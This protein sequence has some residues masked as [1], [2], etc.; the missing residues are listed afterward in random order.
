MAA[1]IE[2]GETLIVGKW[3]LFRDRILGDRIL[4]DPCE[5]RIGD[6]VNDVLQY[7]A[8][9]PEQGGWRRLY[10]DPGDGRLWECSRPR[11][12]MQGGGP[13]ALRVITPERAREVYGWPEPAGDG[14]Q[15][16]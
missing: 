14:D 4:G 6:L 11:M 8:D 5:Q 15:R 2:P 7:L 9:H 13:R 3:I 12:E 1:R 16:S 10:R